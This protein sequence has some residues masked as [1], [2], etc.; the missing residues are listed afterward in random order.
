MTAVHPAR[1]IRKRG[2]DADPDVLRTDAL[3]DALAA[4]RPVGDEHDDPAVRLLQA[5]TADVD[6]RL[7]SVSITPST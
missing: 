7:S 2:P 4:R 3:I 1:S 5:L 6:Q